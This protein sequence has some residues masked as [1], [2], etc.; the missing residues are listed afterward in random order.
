[1][2]NTSSFQTGLNRRQFLKV[3]ILGT[4]VL[5]A[6]GGIASLS[7]CSADSAAPGFRQLRSDDLRMLR[8]LIPVVLAGA[9]PE[10]QQA[11]TVEQVLLSLD[12]NLDRLSPSLNRQVLQ[13]FDLLTTGITRGPVT[14]IWGSWADASDEA[15]SAFLRR[16]ENSSF[17][18][19]QQGQ[20]ALS[21]LILLA[22]YSTPIAWAQCGYPGPP[23]I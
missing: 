17:A 7:G 3:G 2:G 10:S 15:V 12:N 1:M 4:A 8:R 18:L 16:W 5:V 14:G 19:F 11:A 23:R 13:L 22:C 9:M 20:H 6:A 21:N